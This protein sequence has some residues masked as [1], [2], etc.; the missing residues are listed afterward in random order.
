MIGWKTRTLLA[1]GLLAV[2]TSPSAQVTHVAPTAQGTASALRGVGCHAPSARDETLPVGDPQQLG[3]DAPALC[4]LLKDI[5]EGRDNIHSLLILRNGKLVAEL[6]RSGLD[7]T[8]YSLW[9]RRTAFGP[10]VRHDMRSISKS[11]VSLTYGILLAKG[12]VPVLSTPVVSL[13][14]ERPDLDTPERRAIRV[15]HLLSMSAGLDWDE[16]TPIH[17]PKRDDQQPLLWTWSAYDCVFGRD[18]VAEPGS[19][20]VYSGGDTTVLADIMVRA[21]KTDLRTLV[22]TELFEPLG[23]TDWEWTGNIYGEPVAFAGLRLRPRDLMAIGAMMLADGSWQGR[24]IVPKS[25][26]AQSTRSH[27]DTGAGGYGYQFWTSQV[28]WGGRQVAIATALGN[29]GQTLVLVPDLAL[30]IVTTAGDYNDPRIFP[31]ITNI[32]QRITETIRE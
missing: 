30:A 12:K 16:P 20:F 32:A 27:I 6:Y 19:R 8:I 21:T 28:S 4:A 10:T 26:I 17:K 15:E 13:Y 14:P 3:I 9:R 24:Q 25:W 29:G 7:A 22:R 1:I 5:D 31:V 23:I 2:A 11:V 18:V